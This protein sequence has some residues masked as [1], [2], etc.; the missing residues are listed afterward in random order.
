MA[1]EFGKREKI[2]VGVVSLVLSI[3][4]LH[5]LIFMDR[6]NDLAN[7]KAQYD[8]ARGQLPSGA[9]P[10]NFQ[11]VITDYQAETARLKE[12]Y[13]GFYK[14]LN[15][16]TDEAMIFWY[17]KIM[18]FNKG[19]GKY[20]YPG[21]DEV[22]QALIGAVK[23]LLKFRADNP[24]IN[25]TF[26]AADSPNG[27]RLPDGLAP[28]IQS[29]QISLELLLR[30]MSSNLDAMDAY[31]DAAFHTQMDAN[32]RAKRDLLASTPEEWFTL[33]KDPKAGPG[34]SVRTVKLLMHLDLIMAELKRANSK[35][36]QAEAMRALD[37]KLEPFESFHLFRQLQSLV[38]ILEIAK[39]AGVAEVPWVKLMRRVDLL[40]DPTWETQLV[41]GVVTPTPTPTPA[42]RR[43]GYG[44]YGYGGYGGY[45]GKGAKYGGAYAAGYEGGGAV[46]TATTVKVANA[47]PVE[48]DFYGPNPVVASC[49]Y[50][51]ATAPQAFLI[52]QL[53]LA[54]PVQATNPDPEKVAARAQIACLALSDVV[55]KP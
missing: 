9:T 22:A 30:E 26:L 23:E 50:A 16:D 20:P 12:Q 32:Y 54:K 49:L 17:P 2:F 13:V 41:A 21:E 55:Q 11:K 27:W 39:Q 14:P 37:L 10:P 34:E 8:A 46:E 6:H 42:G 18:D 1:V 28:E 44:G 7:S 45:G 52:D 40:Y 29:G 3:A 35:M 19:N 15:I 38:R 43:G 24:S 53:W 33:V 25:L 31:K 5:L 47:M 51:I 36:T 4:A 48:I